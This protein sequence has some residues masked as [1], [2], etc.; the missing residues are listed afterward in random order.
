MRLDGG[1]V[2]SGVVD[3]YWENFRRAAIS[4]QVAK[5]YLSYCE[6]VKRVQILRA[7]LVG[8]KVVKSASKVRV[9]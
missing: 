4:S 3:D 1:G 6:T 9:C 8:E 2:E 5:S 7:I